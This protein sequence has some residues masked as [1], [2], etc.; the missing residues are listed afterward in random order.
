MDKHSDGWKP[1]TINW[2]SQ[3]ITKFL[4]LPDAVTNFRN[5][6]SSGEGY[7]VSDANEKR[8]IVIAVIMACE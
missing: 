8:I 3:N 2:T 5:R 7:M 1:H 4:M 6:T